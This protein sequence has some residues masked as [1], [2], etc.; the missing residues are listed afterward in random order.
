[1]SINVRENNSQDH[2]FYKIF[3]ISRAFLR[4][5]Q[6]LGGRKPRE[7]SKSYKNRGLESCSNIFFSLVSFKTL[8]M[9]SLGAEIGQSLRSK[10][11]LKISCIMLLLANLGENL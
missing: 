3:E 9:A 6:V 4:K 8:L 7:I 1:M 10:S 2:N 11:G 5:K